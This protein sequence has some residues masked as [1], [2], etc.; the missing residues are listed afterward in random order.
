V[1]QGLEGGPKRHEG[2]GGWGDLRERLLKR[3][4]SRASAKGGGERN[5]GGVGRKRK[6][7]GEVSSDFR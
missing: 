5:G 7:R 6:G 1:S 2:R 3:G 4:S